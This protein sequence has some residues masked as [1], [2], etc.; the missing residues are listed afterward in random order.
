MGNVRERSIYFIQHLIWAMNYLP[1]IFG[2]YY[3]M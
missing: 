2:K 3:L 1:T